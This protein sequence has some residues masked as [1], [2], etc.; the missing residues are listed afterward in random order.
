M[1]GARRFSQL[2]RPLIIRSLKG[3]REDHIL[4]ACRR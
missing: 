4:L 3:A 1:I 2:T